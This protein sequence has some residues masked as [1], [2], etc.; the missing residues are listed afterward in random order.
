MNSQI[1]ALLKQLPLFAALHEKDQ[2]ELAAFAVEKRFVQGESIFW[3]G[4]HPDWFYV[5]R[6]GKVRIYKTTSGGKEITLSFFGPGEMFGEVAVLENKAFPASAQAVTAVRLIGIKTS[7]FWDFLLKHPSIALKVLNV[8]AGRLREAQ[9]R[10]RDMAGERVEQ[11]LA[12]LCL[13]LAAKIGNTLPFTRQELSDMAGTSVETTI[14]IL[15]QWKKQ[16]LIDSVRGRIIIMDTQKL[17]QLSEDP[18]N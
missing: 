11:R 12:R 17:E 15:S 8:M 2:A 10:L 1:V 18:A 13:R 3:E 5:I 7:D 16:R 9:S 4:D 6:E 14:R